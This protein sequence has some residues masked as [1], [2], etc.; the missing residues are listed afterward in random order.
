MEVLDV[1]QRRIPGAA[2]TQTQPFQEEVAKP[3]I[4]V[5]KASEGS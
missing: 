2:L 5:G 3:N 1:T 4:D